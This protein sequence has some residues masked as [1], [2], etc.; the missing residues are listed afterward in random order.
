MHSLPFVSVAVFDIVKTPSRAQP[1]VLLQPHISLQDLLPNVDVALAAK[2]Q[3][4]PNLDSA[5]V[6][7]VEETGSLFAMSPDRFPLVVFGDAN[8]EDSDY[9]YDDYGYRGLPSSA[10]GTGF[11]DRDFPPD[12]DSVTRAM[13]RKKLRDLCR[14]GSKDRRCLTG[15]RRLES[16]QLS[17]L[18]DGAATVPN[19][20]F[21]YSSVQGP[22]NA[23]Q[24]PGHNETPITGAGNASIRSPLGGVHLPQIDSV[25]QSGLKTTAQG[26]PLYVVGCIVVLLAIG[27][28]FFKKLS[29]PGSSSEDSATAVAVPVHVESQD[30]RP[31]TTQ[32]RP[33]AVP[34]PALD[35]LLPESQSP[36]L[37]EPEP[38]PREGRET[39][40]TDEEQSTKAQNTNRKVTFGDALKVTG[41]DPDSK[42]DAPGEGE[43]SEGDVPATPGKRKGLRR[44]RGKKKKGNAT[45]G[46]TEEVA[47]AE[48]ELMK[49]P[50]KIADDTPKTNGDAD[51][52]HIVPPSSLVVLPPHTPAVVEPSLIVTENILGKSIL[53]RP[54]KHML[55]KFSRFWFS[56]DRCIQ[57]IATRPRSSSE[58]PP[59]RFCNTRRPRSQHTTGIGRPPERHPVLLPRSSRRV[60]LHCTRALPRVARGRHR[61]PGPIPRN[62]NRLRT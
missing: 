13:K 16:S 11:E 55:I 32:S 15:V 59:T 56:W 50:E 28:G 10:A 57:R 5:Y 6:G 31:E 47:E 39:E 2:A 60:P 43:E 25:L 7:M 33:N 26:F 44:R 45:N 51:V 24:P 9:T 19:S 3:R 42:D 52:V 30:S 27:W 38:L 35:V 53:S 61:A 8:F 36:T 40:T 54:L 29:R 4:L 12:V 18:L 14:A 48:K 37:V 1:F 41:A 22:A 46:V 23:P 17:P 49:P 58:A 62:I 21:H 20:P 34:P